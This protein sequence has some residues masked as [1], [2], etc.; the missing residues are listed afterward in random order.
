MWLLVAVLAALQW[1]PLLTWLSARG[2]ALPLLLLLALLGAGSVVPLLALDRWELRGAVR[3]ELHAREVVFL[4]ERTG[5][6]RLALRWS[7]LRG[8]RDGQAGWV[9][10]VL[11]PDRPTPIPPE[12]LAVPTPDDATRAALLAALDAQ[13][14]VRLE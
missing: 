13:G 12:L 1:S 10:L 9:Q 4:R 14:L 7:E 2:G 11:E 5:H 8:Y 6:A 3:V